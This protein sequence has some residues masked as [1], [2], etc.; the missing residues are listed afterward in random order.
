MMFKT[1]LVFG[2]FISLMIINS[3]KISHPIAFVFLVTAFTSLPDIDHPKSRLGRKLFFLSWPINIVFNH[4]GFFHSIFP[5]IFLYLIF[6]LINLNLLAI[7]IA[8]GYLAHLAGDSITK[9]G[10]RF[11]YPIVKLNIKG[12]ISTNSFFETAIYFILTILNVLL[13][14]KLF[15]IL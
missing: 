11:L 10:I 2:L 7:S 14:A 12:P 15:N 1:H 9:E 3:I 8:I 4:R 13:T 6:K 5:P